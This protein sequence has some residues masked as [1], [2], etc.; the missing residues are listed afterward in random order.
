MISRFPALASRE[1]RIFWIG[2]FISLVGTWMQSTVQPYLAY[3]LTDQPI[4][5][6]LVGFAATLP[7]LLLTLPG[8]VLVERHDKRQVVI[9]MQIIMMAQAFAL[10]FLALTQRINIWHIVGL[11]AVL[12]A[13]NAIEITARQAMLVELVGKEALPNAIALNS[14]IF[15]A[16]RV[17][18]PAVAAPFLLLLGPRGEGWAFFANG[19][20]YAVVI[21]SLL[22]ISRQPHRPP[23]TQRKK[24]LAEFRDGQRYIL[25]APTVAML[26]VMASILGFFATPLSMQIPALA[27]DVLG[28]LGEPQAAVAARNSALVTAQGV[29]ALAAAISLAVLSATVK[30]KGRLLLAGQLAFGLAFT[31]LSFSR[32]LTPALALIAIYGWGM[33]TQLATTNTLIQLIVPDELRGRVISTYLWGLQGVAPFG[34]LLVGWMV[35]QWQL[36]TAVLISGSVCLL[37]TVIIHTL[38]P[39]LRRIVA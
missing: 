1:F 17:L 25:R 13:A 35:Q 14:T 29:G 5:L 18:G 30:R 2:Q 28:H 16:A 10:A 22:T 31:G 21:I 39:G 9:A 3:R 8:G 27:R 36:P 34:S 19:V 7:A 6:G 33:V 15:N 24:L 12:G 23:Q 32:T 26:V 38:T 11:A 20:S 37:S 4:Y